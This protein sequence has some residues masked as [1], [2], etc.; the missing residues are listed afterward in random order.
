MN[1]LRLDQISEEKKISSYTP[2]N[3]DNHHNKSESKHEEIKYSRIAVTKIQEITIATSSLVNLS[4]DNLWITIYLTRSW[5]KV[6][7]DRSSELGIRILAFI[8]KSRDQ[9]IRIQRRLKK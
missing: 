7:M 8:K 4:M 3:R 2:A 1:S 9:I 6:H 5:K